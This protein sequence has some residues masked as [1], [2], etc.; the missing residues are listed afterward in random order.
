[1]LQEICID[2]GHVSENTLLSRCLTNG[3]LRAFLLDPGGLYV[4]E[5]GE[6]SGLWSTLSLVTRQDALQQRVG[7][8]LCPGLVGGDAWGLI[9]SSLFFPFPVS[10][11]VVLFP[12]PWPP[13]GRRGAGRVCNSLLHF[14]HLVRKTSGIGLSQ[15]VGLVEFVYLATK[16]ELPMPKDCRLNRRR[17]ESLFSLKVKWTGKIVF[18]PFVALPSLNTKIEPS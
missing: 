10:H 2:A 7:C 5:N 9:S 4:S 18:F 16:R 12:R 8:H 3:F 1:M 15:S 14:S 11:F 13:L 17:R 6:L